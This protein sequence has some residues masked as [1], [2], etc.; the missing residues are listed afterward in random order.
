ML[1]DANTAPPA[2]DPKL[3]ASVVQEAVAKAAAA[4]IPEIRQQIQNESR[5]AAKDFSLACSRE[6]KLIQSTT[7]RG[8]EKLKTLAQEVKDQTARLLA[9][10]E[11]QRDG[12][13]FPLL[14]T[15]PFVH[16]EEDDARR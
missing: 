1:E 3:L 2:V 11:L 8:E 5:E 4:L 10:K 7:E 13:V 16:G 14:V 9:A 12:G 15:T 6:R